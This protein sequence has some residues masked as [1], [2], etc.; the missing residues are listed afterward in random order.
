MQASQEPIDVV[1]Q[2]YGR[3][4]RMH[5]AAYEQLSRSLPVSVKGIIDPRIGDGPE[6]TRAGL[7]SWHPAVFRDLEDAQQ[8]LDLSNAILDICSPNHLHVTN[9]DEA[10]EAGLKY[11]IVEKPATLHYEDLQRI[12]SDPR[13]NTTVFHNYVVSP[14]AR[15]VETLLAKYALR[16][17]WIE[18]L[19]SKDRR[20]DSQRGRGFGAGIPIPH[21]FWIEM[22][23]Q[24]SLSVLFAGRVR[25]VRGA[26][27]WSMQLPEHKTMPWH[28]G[29]TM[30]LEH[31]SGVNSYHHTSLQEPLQRKI[32]VHCDHGCVIV[33]AFGSGQSLS[34]SVTLSMFGQTV[35]YHE[36]TDESIVP[37]LAAAIAEVRRQQKASPHTLLDIG[38]E[39][40]RV[41]EQGVQLSASKV[42]RS[43][44]A[45]DSR[46][47]WPRVDADSRLKL[48]SPA[49]CENATEM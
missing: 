16:I 12:A 34:G 10:I 35:E 48:W 28:G 25:R 15:L 44:G 19:M 31:E 1:I 30:V 43:L 20:I 26:T 49:L 33:G 6:D 14:V 11:L 29:G 9:A 4:G 2:G 5:L 18:T 22:P 21:A 32:T 47:L 39:V 38:M 24:V 8:E 3:A 7:T 17:D 45:D 27:C 41:I 40:V 36:V 42:Q 37:C 13:C 23:H 46:L